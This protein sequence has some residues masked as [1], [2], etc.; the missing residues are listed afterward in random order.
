MDGKAGVVKR[1]ERTPTAILGHSRSPKGVTAPPHIHLCHSIHVYTMQTYYDQEVR[2]L[3][4]RCSL[5]WI[6]ICLRLYR[7]KDTY[8]NPTPKPSIT[9][10][11]PTSQLRHG[12]IKNENSRHKTGAKIYKDP[13]RRCPA[14]QDAVPDI[15]L[16]QYS[17]PYAL[18]AFCDMKFAAQA[19]SLPMRFELFQNP[20][21]RNRS[22]RHFFFNVNDVD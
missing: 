5:L 9:G 22:I 12:R 10:R 17:N 21:P 4:R 6:H 16:A 1:V 19:S 15:N 14:P 8:Q 13:S 20:I 3:S 7:L 18:S 11:E 2:S